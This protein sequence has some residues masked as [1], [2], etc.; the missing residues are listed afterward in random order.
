MIFD[1]VKYGLVTIS[2]LIWCICIDAHAISLKEVEKI[3]LKEAPELAQLRHS[4]YSLRESAVAAGQLSDPKLQAGLINVP[5]DSFDLDQENMT[6]MKFSLVQNFPK[7]RTLSVKSRQINM[8]AN[9]E[10]FKTLDTKGKILQMVRNDW[11]SLYYWYEADKII[12]E[13]KRIFKQLVE[14]TES[15]LAAGK[16]S[17]HDVLR[18]YLELSKIENHQI[19]IKKEIGI[20]HAN[21]ARWVGNGISNQIIPN[22]LPQWLPPPSSELLSLLVKNHPQIKKD[23]SV[24]SASR[25]GVKLAKQEYFP[26][27]AL[28]LSYSYRRGNIPNM[29]NKRADFVGAQVTLDLPVFTKNRQNKVLKASKENL[30]AMQN[31]QI[32][33]YRKMTAEAEQELVKWKKLTEQKKLYKDKLIPES[34]QHAKATL[35][36]YQNDK[37]DFLTVIR[38]YIIDLDTQLEN[39]KINVDRAK[40]RVSLFYLEGADL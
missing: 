37:S 21:L 26:G 30:H 1:R 19:H 6:Q 32:S 38:A 15:M 34:K 35:I 24:I 27:W 39:L 7:G 31:I 4:E 40:T 20:S 36:A 10:S 11:L 16:K 18:A 2:S 33:D 17:Q 13:N 3:A 8:L 5:T 9:A 14:I 25:Q 29:D 28:N 12:K 23:S 22:K